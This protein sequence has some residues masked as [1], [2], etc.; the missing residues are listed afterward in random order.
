MVREGALSDA[1][2]TG[3]I[4][5]AGTVIGGLSGYGVAWRQ[6][7]STEYAADVARADRQE[8]V[9]RQAYTTFL[10][11]CDLLADKLRELQGHDIPPA[12]DDE[13]GVSYV[14]VWHSAVQ[15]RAVVELAGPKEVAT[16]ATALFRILSANCNL[17]DAWVDGASWTDEDDVE[18]TANYEQRK[19]ER[20]AFV[21]A[22]TASL[23]GS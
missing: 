15:A 23:S 17:I 4:G 13:L 9:R 20:Q 18:F 10:T 22:G 3:I 8:D 21:D 7:R 12:W 11:N 6:G 19:Q 5:L 1:L 14:N 16:A 2:A